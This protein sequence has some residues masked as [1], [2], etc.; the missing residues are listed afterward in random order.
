MIRPKHFGSH[1]VTFL[2]WF[3]FDNTPHWICPDAYALFQQDKE[4]W[5]ARSGPIPLDMM[6]QQHLRSLCRMFDRR[7][8][9]FEVSAQLCWIAKQPED[10]PRWPWRSAKHW[11]INTPLYQEVRRRTLARALICAK[12]E[13]GE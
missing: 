4:W 5:P 1:T 9:F 7:P 2:P 12:V 10:E 8:E 6:T 3:A 13:S 11:M